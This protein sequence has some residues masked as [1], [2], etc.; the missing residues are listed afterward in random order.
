MPFESRS[1]T[2]TKPLTPALSSNLH[3]RPAHALAPRLA[4]ATPTSPAP[5][6][7]RSLR[8][9][10]LSPE[11]SDEGKTLSLNSNITPRSG[12]RVSR[13]DTDSPSTPEAVAR[14]RAVVGGI[15]DDTQTISCGL[16]ISSPA[17]TPTHPRPK[18][19][20]QFSFLP[21][22]NGRRISGGNAAASAKGDSKFFRADD[23]KSSVSSP[24]LT[25]SRPRTCYFSRA[26]SPR[27]SP[28]KV[29]VN[30][31]DKSA[32]KFFYANNIPSPSAG[33][34]TKSSLALKLSST[35]SAAFSTSSKPS[36]IKRGALNKC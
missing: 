6:Q 31:N 35:S 16:G 9:Q 4:G 7:R 32:D 2:T 8:Q 14:T 36:V 33:G 3:A 29:S 20:D 5:A 27:V 23:V 24:R 22:A 18:S 13:L 12:A 21:T 34:P 1:R 26:P 10:T 19:T 25:G 30:G 15:Q 11:S 28:K 17:G